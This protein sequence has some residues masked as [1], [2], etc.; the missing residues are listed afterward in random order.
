M[1]KKRQDEL[2]TTIRITR[3]RLEVSGA[4]VTLPTTKMAPV[5]HPV[6][7]LDYSMQVGGAVGLRILT[8]LL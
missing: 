2:D 5:P 4:G 7:H 1:E 8:Q 6:W 3:E